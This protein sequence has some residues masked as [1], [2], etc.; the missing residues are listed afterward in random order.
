MC[1]RTG[2]TFFFSSRPGQLFGKLDA[3]YLNGLQWGDT[4][5]E[6]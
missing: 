3:F 2:G 4:C 1:R 5:T 6:D